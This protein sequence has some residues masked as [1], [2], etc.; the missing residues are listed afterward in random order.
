MGRIQGESV[1]IYVRINGTGK[2]QQ[3]RKSNSLLEPTG[4]EQEPSMK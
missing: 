2:K 3:N 4:R 1:G